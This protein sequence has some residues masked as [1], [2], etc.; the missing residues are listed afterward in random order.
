MA[1]ASPITRPVEAKVLARP[2][3]VGCHFSYYCGQ[4]GCHCCV[5][6][7]KSFGNSIPRVRSRSLFVPVHPALLLAQHPGW[8]MCWVVLTTL[9]CNGVCSSCPKPS[10]PTFLA[11]LI[12]L[13]LKLE[14]TGVQRINYRSRKVALETMPQSLSPVMAISTCYRQLA[15]SN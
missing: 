6:Y 1:P 2:L 9:M 4:F 15:P 13:P 12:R 7:T 8:T 5:P 11:L 3:M 10:L 14:S